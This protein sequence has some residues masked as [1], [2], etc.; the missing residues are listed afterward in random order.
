MKWMLAACLMLV[1]CA[2]HASGE[3]ELVVGV[4]PAE[5]FI[6]VADD[7]SVSGWGSTCSNIYWLNWRSLSLSPIT[8][9]QTFQRIWT[10]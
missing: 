5:P 7:G 6:I 8:S 9:T 2:S 4:K 10:R 3:S 1:L